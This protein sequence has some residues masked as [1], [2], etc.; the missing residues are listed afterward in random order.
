MLYLKEDH[1]ELNAVV[2]D[3]GNVLLDYSPL[4]IMGELG[5]PP[6]L[7]QRLFAVLGG[8]PDW[9]CLDR[10]TMHH[11]DLIQK[12]SRQ[13]PSLKK[14]IRLFVNHWADRFF[15]IPQNV[16][17]FYRIKEAGAKTYILSNFSEDVWNAI[18]P[19]NAFLDDFDGAVLSFQHAVIKPEAE[20]YHLL[21]DTYH[22][23]PAHSVFFDD[24]PE[25]VEASIAAGLPAVQFPVGGNL[26][27]FF[28]FEE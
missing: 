5:I 6:E 12:A 27:G 26:S 1:R 14:E 8:S 13:E 10:N 17:A 19:R 21:L 9:Y 25:N 28:D 18:Y 3:L 4:R 23:D 20:I 11:A 2:F 22:L 7:H 15:A 24:M 16:E